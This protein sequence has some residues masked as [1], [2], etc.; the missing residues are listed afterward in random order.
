MVSFLAWL[1]RPESE[2]LTFN[3]LASGHSSVLLPR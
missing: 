1:V 3:A 2:K